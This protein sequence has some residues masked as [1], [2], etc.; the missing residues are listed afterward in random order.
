MPKVLTFGTL[1]ARE[2]P[3]MGV[4]FK[5]TDFDFREAG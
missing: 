1:N 5:I 4:V 3:F 2:P